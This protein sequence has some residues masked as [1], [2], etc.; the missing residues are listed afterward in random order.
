[1]LFLLLNLIE[2]H[3]LILKYNMLLVVH[4]VHMLNLLL[5]FLSLYM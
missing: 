4:R 1:M 5:S 3:L 2:L